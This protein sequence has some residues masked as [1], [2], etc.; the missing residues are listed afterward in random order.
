MKTNTTS[1][2]YSRSIGNGS[3]GALTLKI[4]LANGMLALQSAMTVPAK[5]SI[6]SHS[7]C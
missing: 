3:F 2:N 4:T 5:R 7:T 6:F 1:V